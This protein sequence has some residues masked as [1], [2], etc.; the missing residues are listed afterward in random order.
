MSMLYYTCITVLCWLTLGAMTVL[1][2]KNRRI[3]RDTKKI[4][5]L[6]YVL[7]A[8][9]ALARASMSARLRPSGR[10]SITSSGLTVS[11]AGAGDGMI[12]SAKSTAPT[13]A[14]QAAQI[15]INERCFIS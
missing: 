9:A 11:L 4:L 2:Y 15:A 12:K 3:D 13:V 6:T 7:A 1:V 10:R 14:T 5:Y 8:A